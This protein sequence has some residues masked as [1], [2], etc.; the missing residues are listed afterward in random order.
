MSARW[1]GTVPP[2]FWKGLPPKEMAEIFA[3][4]YFN[5]W[6]CRRL[7]ALL[8]RTDR[9]PKRIGPILVDKAKLERWLETRKP[10]GK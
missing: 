10:V 9:P 8:G 5:A 6:A 2:Q 7:W 3:T 1:H 4:G